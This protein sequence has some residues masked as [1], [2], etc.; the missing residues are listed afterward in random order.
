[1]VNKRQ[2]LDNVLKVI[3]DLL[4]SVGAIANDSLCEHI[5]ATKFID[6]TNPRIEIELKLI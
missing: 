3:S 4:Q 1:M 2:D 6:K 5:E